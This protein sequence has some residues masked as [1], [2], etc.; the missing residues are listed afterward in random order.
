MAGAG[1]DRGPHAGHGPGAHHDRRGEQGERSE[2]AG[3]ASGYAG[4]D[5]RHTVAF[6]GEPR[7][8]GTVHQVAG[9]PPIEETTLPDPV[10][11]ILASTRAFDPEAHLALLGDKRFHIAPDGDAFLMYGVHRRFWIAV[12]A[13]VGAPHALPGLP[14]RFCAAARAAGAQPAFTHLGA[15]PAARLAGLGMAV[16]PMGAAASIVPGTFLL[17]GSARGSLR[18]SWR[19]VR[20]L[21]GVRFRVHGDAGP[22]LP[23][24]RAVSD[25]WLAG[26]RETGFSHG[27]FLPAFLTGRPVAVLR[28]HGTVVAFVSLWPTPDRRLGVDLMRHSPA[29]PPGAMDFLLT[30]LILWAREAELRRVDLGLA[31]LSDLTGDDALSRLGRL[32][33]RHGE[34]FHGFAGLRHF[35]AKF[36]PEWSPRFVVAPHRHQLPLVLG[37]VVLLG[38]ATLTAP[39]SRRSEPAPRWPGDRTGFPGGSR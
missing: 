8:P 25:A 12:G 29:A 16:H 27:V 37:R 31:P 3:R 20:D 5:D 21:G 38:R 6:P 28:V 33:L 15:G 2:R 18:R 17:A 4:S 39:G 24:L 26:R 23:E 13:P 35:K 19:R 10:P 9:T 1:P 30:E 22:L 36:R 14:A 34:R 32:V 11:A 7:R